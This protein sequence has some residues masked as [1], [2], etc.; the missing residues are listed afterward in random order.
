VFCFELFLSGVDLKLG[1]AMASSSDDKEKT[2]S[3]DVTKDF[4]LKEEV[5]S[6]DE[7]EDQSSRPNTMIASIGVVTDHD[8]FKKSARIRTGGGVPHHTLAPGTSPSGN[9]P[10]HTLIH[11]H[12]FQRVPRSR[13]PSGWDIDHSNSAGKESSKSEKGLVNNSKSWDS[14]ADRFMNCVE[15]NSEIIRNLSHKID[16]LKGLIE[17]LIK[18]YPP[19]PPKE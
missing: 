14:L 12:Q 1:G 5:E 9:N 19:P 7:E 2:P 17:K 13:L 15:H 10:F 6:E 3:E 4:R 18:D 8:K 16:D 11:E